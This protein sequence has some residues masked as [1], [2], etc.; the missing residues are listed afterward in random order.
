VKDREI[1][2]DNGWVDTYNAARRRLHNAGY[3]VGGYVDNGVP[4]YVLY[5]VTD[6]LSNFERIHEFD[7]MKELNNM[8]KLILPPEGE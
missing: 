8:V 4:K 6:T 1:E 3:S 7:S 5:R 2:M